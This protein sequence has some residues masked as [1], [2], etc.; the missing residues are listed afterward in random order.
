MPEQKNHICAHCKQV[1]RRNYD[2]YIEKVFKV[3]Y[4]SPNCRHKEQRLRDKDKIIDYKCQSCGSLV[5]GN[6]LTKT[7]KYCTN[8]CKILFSIS[9]SNSTIKNEVEIL[10]PSEA[11]Q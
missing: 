4:C 5:R 7:R 9:K 8:K 1:F 10:T 2:I 11:M 6:K 3:M